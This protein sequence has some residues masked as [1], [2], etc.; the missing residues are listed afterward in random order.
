LKYPFRKQQ[1]Y[2]FPISSTSIYGVPGLPGKHEGL[3]YCNLTCAVCMV[4]HY[5]YVYK[6]CMVHWFV[7]L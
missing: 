3:Y 1:L 2:I 6:L 7:V 4:T 5:K